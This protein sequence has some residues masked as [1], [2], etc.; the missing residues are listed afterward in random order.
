MTTPGTASVT[1]MD[2]YTQLGPWY[3]ADLLH[4]SFPLL[5]FVDSIMN[6]L[7]I[8]E[9][10]TRD[11][12]THIG[13]GQLLDVNVCPTFA[14]PWLAQFCGVTYPVGASDAQ[15]RSFIKMQPGFARGTVQSM[16]N[17]AEP[18]LSGDQVLDVQERWNGAYTIKF[19]SS[20]ADTPGGPTGAVALSVLAALLATKPAGIVV[21]YYVGLGT[22][23]AELSGTWSSL[24]GTWASFGSE[25]L[26]T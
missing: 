17:A 21:S 8:S 14:L 12:P 20:I 1:T 11:D 4:P 23:W 6:Q 15:M 24:S 9:Q 13:W 16:L 25:T 26:V 7:D 5:N 10:Y 19:R 2:V 18:L 22:T 3:E